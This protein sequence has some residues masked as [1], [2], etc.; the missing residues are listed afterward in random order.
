MNGI[1]L[2]HCTAHRGPDAISRSGLDVFDNLSYKA[3]GT[4]ALINM[5]EP[6]D[7]N[8]FAIKA[9][10]AYRRAAGTP[11]VKTRELLEHLAKSYDRLTIEADFNIRLREKLGQH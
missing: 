7:R 10:R 6:F 4:F 3:C 8:Y 11:D 9:A 5:P 2:R 1:R